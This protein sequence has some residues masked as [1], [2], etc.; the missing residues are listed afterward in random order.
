MH[1]QLTNPWHEKQ[2]NRVKICE[3]WDWGLRLLLRK[4]KQPWKIPN[5]QQGQEQAAKKNDLY[6]QNTEPHSFSP[7]QPDY[8][9]YQSH[10]PR[11]LMAESVVP[12]RQLPLEGLLNSSIA[13]SPALNVKTS[14]P[15]LCPH[16]FCLSHRYGPWIW[17]CAMPRTVTESGTYEIKVHIEHWPWHIRLWIVSGSM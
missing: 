10:I 12:S 4:L 2:M 9:S 11:L 7:S 16:W 8:S 5:N 14:G 3:S 6:V 13:T 1:I 15:L 17:V